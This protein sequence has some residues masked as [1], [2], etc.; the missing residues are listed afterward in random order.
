MRFNNWFSFYLKY[1]QKPRWDTGISPPELITY[2][3][4]HPTGRALDLGCGT[5]TNL[6]KMAQ[7]GW[8]VVGVDFIPTAVHAARRKLSNKGLSGKVILGS[9]TRLYKFS[10]PFNLVLDIGCFHNL[11]VNQKKIYIV[12]LSRYLK[13]GGNFLLYAHYKQ[14]EN[15][16]HGIDDGDLSILANNLIQLKISKSYETWKDKPG[17]KKPSVWGLFQKR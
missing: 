13:P 2:L 1:Q 11:T 5:G 17:L 16:W 12:N 8:I 7:K 4:T 15:D 14:N 9:V 10:E 3:D 6:V